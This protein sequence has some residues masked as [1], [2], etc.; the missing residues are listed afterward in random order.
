MRE[1][2]TQTNMKKI[3]IKLASLTIISVIITMNLMMVASANGNEFL[4]KLND[5]ATK[6]K[7][8]IKTT[9]VGKAIITVTEESYVPDSSDPAKDVDLGNGVTARKCYRQTMIYTSLDNKTPAI[10]A[11][12]LTK[13]CG[14]ETLKEGDNNKITGQIVCDEVTVLIATQGGSAMIQAYISMMYRW[15]ASLAGIIA[16]LVI[17]VS[18]LQ[19]SLAGGGGEGM[20]E[21]KGRIIKSLSGLALLFLS[22]LILYTLN[23]TFFTKPASTSAASPAAQILTISSIS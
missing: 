8:C 3:F 21:A 7:D 23:P 2:T 11:S 18:G 17:I 16:V 1:V 19:I 13:T 9:E 6:E 14:A 20:D 12:G 5:F 10:S 4:K 15:V 22:A